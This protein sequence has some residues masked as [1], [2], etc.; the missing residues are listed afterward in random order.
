MNKLSEFKAFVSVVEH[1]SFSEAANQLFITKSSVSKKVSALEDRLSVKLLHRTTRRLSVTEPG[2]LYYDKV[3]KIILDCEEADEIVSKE[4]KVLT[5]TLKITAPISFASH[6]LNPLFR[7]YMKENEEIFLDINL[8]EKN[9]NIVEEGIDLALRI[10]ILTDSNLM[11]KRLAPIKRHLYASPAYLEKFGCPQTPEE[12]AKHTMLKHAYMGKQLYL[13]DKKGNEYTVQKSLKLSINHG[14][15]LVET[16]L[17]GY[18]IALLPTFMTH[19]ECKEG[20]L[21]RILSAYSVPEFSLYAVYPQTQYLSLKVRKFIDLLEETFSDKP[22][23]DV[24]C[25][26]L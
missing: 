7:R 11:A 25:Q 23:W 2:K 15:M 17:K 9:I 24:D 1:G 21:V 16:A 8:D 6:H 12:L 20:S 14:D 19:K 3:K 26:D 4:N 5:G 13:T 18:G 22:Y 10:G